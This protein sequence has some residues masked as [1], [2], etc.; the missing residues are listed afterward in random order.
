MAKFNDYSRY[1]QRV[2]AVPFEFL[3]ETFKVRNSQWNLLRV[4]EAQ[5]ASQELNNEEAI[6]RAK[7]EEIKEKYYV[8]EDEEGNPEYDI[9]SHI[10]KELEEEQAEINTKSFEENAK[11]QKCI[12]QIL[13]ESQFEKLE[14]LEISTETYGVLVL[15][16]FGL[17]SGMTHEEIMKKLD[18]EFENNKGDQT[19]K[20]KS[21]NKK[22]HNKKK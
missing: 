17:V 9:P 11:L 7:L 15:I 14:K 21:N 2:E 16:I 12:K 8:G 3:G 10:E 4:I 20:K 18:E 6:F 13:G 5:K 22:K 1:A 19:S